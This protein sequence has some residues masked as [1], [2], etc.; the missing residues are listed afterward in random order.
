MATVRPKKGA[1]LNNAVRTRRIAAQLTQAELGRLVGVSRQTVAQIEAGRS[2]P[3]ALI[4]L[5]LSHALGAPVDEL[6]WIGE[7]GTLRS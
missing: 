6:F 4:A 1:K 2:A 7:A 5:K 3:S